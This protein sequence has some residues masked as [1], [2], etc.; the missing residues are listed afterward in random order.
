MSPSTPPRW[1]PASSTASVTGLSVF[2]SAAE[3]YDRYAERI[4]LESAFVPEAIYRAARATILKGLDGYQA[5][6]T[7]A[8]CR[9]EH[10]AHLNLRREIHFLENG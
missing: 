10:Q 3:T 8:L 9:L 7:P 4:G 1:T 2:G 6:K 5:F